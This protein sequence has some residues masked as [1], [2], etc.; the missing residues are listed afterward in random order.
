MAKTTLFWF[1]DDLRLQDNELLSQAASQ[2]DTLLCVYVLPKS[3]LHAQRIGERKLQ[4]LQQSLRDLHRQLS[5]LGQR[6][7]VLT[8]EPVSA[9]QNLIDAYHVTHLARAQHPGAEERGWLATIT[10]AN[11]ELS[12]QSA[13][14][15]RLWSNAEL[16]FSIDELPPTFSQARKQLEALNVKPPTAAPDTLPPP[17]E[18]MGDVHE[19]ALTQSNSASLLVH[20][21]SQAAQRHLGRYFSST[22]PSVYKETRN[23]LDTFSHSTKFSPWLARGCLSPR[24]IMAALHAYEEEQGANEST[25]WIF[26]ELMWREYFHL[27]AW[28]DN[29]RLFHQHG[30]QEELPYALDP[31]VDF[32]DWCHGRTPFPLVNACM[33]QLNQTGY[34][35]NRGRQLAA[36]CLVNEM[37]IDWR[38]GAAWF[39]RQLIDYDVASN[40]GNWQYLAGV[41]ADPR[42]LRRF[43][44]AKQQNTYDPD[45]DFVERWRGN[46]S[47]TVHVRNGRHFI[48]L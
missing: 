10:A 20:G 48:S 15:L 16:P 1:G 11:P 6:L 5:A 30:H 28:R 34:M 41:G 8:D 40:W 2:T 21:G 39:E 22:A 17:P 44:Q 4:F 37:G 23:T 3:W 14:S 33:H 47:A 24:E 38:L 31:N 27:Y 13:D 26:F 42:G 9:L 36:S 43:N 7:H 12:V 46:N 18:D 25:Y 35:S 29:D 32:K 45:G 19:I